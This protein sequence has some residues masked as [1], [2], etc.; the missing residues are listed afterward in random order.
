MLNIHLKVKF[1]ELHGPFLRFE[2]EE[3][4]RIKKE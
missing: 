3:I 1:E 4:E 2:N